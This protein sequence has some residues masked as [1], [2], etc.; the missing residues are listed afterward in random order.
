MK[1]SVA[2]FDNFTVSTPA[3]ISNLCPKT[4]RDELI[5]LERKFIVLRRRGEVVI[6]IGPLLQGRDSYYHKHILVASKNGF[7]DFKISG[8]GTFSLY[9]E[10]GWKSWQA[11]FYGDSGE[12]G[13][14]DPVILSEKNRKQISG[15]IGLTRVKFSFSV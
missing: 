11:N 5:C 14:Y 12:F 1:I 10:K 13:V 3:P 6:A 4:E 15:A 8:G 7:G 9:K 2:L